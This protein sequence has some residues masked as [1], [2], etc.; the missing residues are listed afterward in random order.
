MA[1]TAPTSTTNHDRQQFDAKVGQI[2][3]DFWTMANHLD[4]DGRVDRNK[5]LGSLLGARMGHQV[6]HSV[7]KNVNWE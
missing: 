2:D 7:L 1:P 3:I 6:A 4:T 5:R